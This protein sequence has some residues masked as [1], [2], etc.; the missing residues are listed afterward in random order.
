[1]KRFLSFL[2]VW[3]I[4]LSVLRG[5]VSFAETEPADL[6]PADL[7]AT[8]IAEDDLHPHGSA[9][10]TF[11][12]DSLPGDT[13]DNTLTWYVGIEKKIG[14]D[15]WLEVNLV[16]TITM[17]SDYTMGGGGYRFEQLW[18][19]DDAWDGVKPVSYRV[20]VLLDDLV[21]NRGGK[22]GYS[23]VVTLGLTASGWAVPELEEAQAYGLIPGILEGKDL[24][25]MV[26]REEFCELAV[27]LYE[28]VT[29]KAAVAEAPN[30]FTDTT[31]T[32]ILKAFKL[33]ITAGYPNNLFKPGELIPREQCAT[34]L[35]RT[36]KVIA[37]NG[38]Y[39]VD[40]AKP[41]TDQKN[42]SNWALDAARYMSLKGIVKGDTAGNFMPKA[43][44]SDQTA[45]GFGLATREA[46]IIMSKRAYE[47]MKGSSGTAASGTGA[48]ATDGTGTTSGSTQTTSGS[49]VTA[50]LVAD[51]ALVGLW[52]KDGASGTI[53]DPATGFA[54]GSVYN[55]EWYLFRD[56][57][58][59]RYVIVS[60]SQILS[61]GV[62]WEGKYSVAD[63]AVRLT[64]TLEAWH[65][66][67][68]VPGQAAAYSNMKL[69]NQ[70]IPYQIEDNGTRLDMGG[71]EIFYKV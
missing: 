9:L 17:L 28:E 63:G 66:N 50:A 13:G 19:E 55:G 18:V 59:F 21:G 52:S 64:D 37:P 67:V 24:S 40:G 27:L 7:K 41:F 71:T 33:G 45:R 1:M 6:T 61:G 34:M 10:L 56:D 43:V 65:P 26:T 48:A 15:E 3:L 35:F 62:V 8:L 42:I 22:S 11:H 70:T 38:D 44:T 47:D 39:R 25:K 29:G 46:A 68:A 69:A 16:P 32:Q 30:P 2:F 54:T 57:G 14:D 23:N 4:A 60:S 36:I 20:Y 53:V 49:T 12:I 5:N 51:S 31:N 58:T